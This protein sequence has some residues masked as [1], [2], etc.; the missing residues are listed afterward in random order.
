[1]DAR[2]LSAY[3]IMPE[4]AFRVIQLWGM[5]ADGIQSVAVAV[6]QNVRHASQ[7]KAR[8]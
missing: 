5:Y 7:R 2:R 8:F 1:M 4:E 6:K 3:A